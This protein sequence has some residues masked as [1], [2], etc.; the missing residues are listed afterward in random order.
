M[1]LVFQEKIKFKENFK[2]KDKGG[3]M[4]GRKRETRAA[5][6]AFDNQRMEE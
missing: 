6:A 5:D 1:F 2:L 3:I 4:I